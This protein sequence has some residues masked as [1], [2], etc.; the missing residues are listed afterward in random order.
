MFVAVIILSL[1]GFIFGISLAIVSKF[2]KIKVDE[3]LERICKILPGANCGACGKA[4][5][6]GFAQAILS[7][8]LSLDCCK[9]ASNEAKVLIADI[10]GI[11]FE[12]KVRLVAV[13]HCNGG[14]KVK[15]KFI[16]NGIEDCIYANL[17][18]G[19][20]K[21]CFWGCLGFGTCV[22][23]CPFGAISM[24][25][26][27]IPIID[28]NKCTGCGKCVEICPKKLFSLVPVNYDVYVACNSFD[29]GKLTRKI[30]PVG[31]IACGICT[32]VTNSTFYIKD[33]LAYIDYDKIKDEKMLYEA[34]SKCPVKCI[35]KRP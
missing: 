1:L 12:K 15:D 6:F 9:V 25:A 21:E 17:E 13:V 11:K 24:S 28:T 26:E 14:C 7:R 32:K 5:C 27:K 23:A 33:N 31:C 16:Y 8:E 35:V 29:V 22:N 34:M 4:G 20:Q 3:K 19:G 30:C 2:L 10:L 18:L